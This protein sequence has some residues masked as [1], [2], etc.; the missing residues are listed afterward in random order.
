MKIDSPNDYFSKKM[1]RSTSQLEFW[2]NT[3]YRFIVLE[4]FM[5]SK[6]ISQVIHQ[7]SD[8]V[9]LEQVPL[10]Q[11]FEIPGWGLAY[12]LQA[13][14]IGC[15]SIFLVKELTSLIKFNTFVKNSWEKIDQDDMKLLG[16][17][18]ARKDVKILPSIPEFDYIFDAGTYGRYLLGTD[19][20]NNRN[21]FSRR[22]ISDS[23]EGS[24]DPGRERITFEL[25]KE[26]TTL[27][28]FR[29]SK[30][31]KLVNI[32]IHSKRIPA[33]R[34]A[35]NRMIS[36][37]IKSMGTRTWVIGRIDLRVFSERLISW[38]LRRILRKDKDIRLR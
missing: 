11:L 12:P 30:V 36:H 26:R 18:S 25:S 35:L 33:S 22:G 31:S 2:I 24:I 3:T 9:I 37:D 34:A 38:T 27:L 28:V 10:D 4:E 21:P 14:E 5:R 6:K 7:E 20:R 15:A 17:F 8:N 16:E 23:R 19:A 29:N 13:K 1:R 32:H